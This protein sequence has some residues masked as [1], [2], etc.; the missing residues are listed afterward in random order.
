[1]TTVFPPTTFSRVPGLMAGVFLLGFAIPAQAQFPPERLENLQVLSGDLT[2]REVIDVMRGFAIGLGVRCSHCHV[3]EEGQPLST[4]DFASDEKAP[5]RKARSMIEMVN[6]INRQHL[7]G[8]E[9]RGTPPLAVTCTTC[10]RGQ[11]RPILIEDA[12]AS[13]VQEGGAEAGVTKYRELRQRYYGSHTYDFREFVLTNVA[14]RVWNEDPDAA[15][16]L[17]ELNLEFFPDSDQTLTLL[18]QAYA[19]TG[20]RDKAIA[21]LERAIEL[22]PQNPQARRALQ[23]LLGGSD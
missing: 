23:Q 8:L 18:G 15:I 2:P 14:S 17:G 19:A 13:A 9:E 4:Y 3:G 5:K 16:A 1:M 12:L 21:A 10:H 11:A 20:Q 6:T 7:A 22:N